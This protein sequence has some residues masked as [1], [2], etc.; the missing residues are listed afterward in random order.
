M[1]KCLWL[2]PVEVRFGGVGALTRLA[3]HHRL[4]V[5]CTATTASVERCVVGGSGV[6]SHGGHRHFDYGI[7]NIEN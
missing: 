1:A 4:V 6:L 7:I 2:L 3:H 5:G